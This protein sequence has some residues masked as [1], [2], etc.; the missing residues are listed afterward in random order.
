M[1]FVSLQ[2]SLHL[3]AL[4]SNLQNH[5]GYTYTFWNLTNKVY[6]FNFLL[7]FFSSDCWLRCCT[8]GR[9]V[10]INCLQ[11]MLCPVF[12]Q[13][14]LTTSHYQVMQFIWVL[15]F[16]KIARLWVNARITLVYSRTPHTPS[17]QHKILPDI[18]MKV[19]CKCLKS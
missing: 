9:K 13:V 18:R 16:F 6:L 10:W 8:S 4:E 2:Y 1:W 19:S 11:F 7:F 14:L 3:V 12:V 5:S 17:W 15:V